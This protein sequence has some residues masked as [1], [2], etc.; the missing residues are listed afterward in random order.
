MIVPRDKYQSFVGVLFADVPAVTTFECRVKRI[1]IIAG[2]AVLVCSCSA[3][4][5]LSGVIEATSDAGGGGMSSTAVLARVDL[6]TLGGRTSVAADINSRDVVVGSS[7]TVT[8]AVHGFRWSAATGMVD[9]GTLAGDDESRAVAILDGNM[10]GGGEILGLS[11]R[12]GDWTP[13]VW[14]ASGSISALPI[15][16]LPDAQLSNP[17]GFNMRGQVIGSDA[18]VFQHAWVWSAADGKYDLTANAPPPGQSTEGIA[19]AITG[20]GSVLV[21]TR[22]YPYTCRPVQCWRAY[23]WSERT[24]YVALGTPDDD[25]AVGVIGYGLNDRGTVVGSVTNAQTGVSPYRW[26]GGSG[27]TLLARLSV[28]YSVGHAFAVN[29]SGT[30]VGIDR[31]PN[32]GVSVAT[33]WPPSGGIVRL[34][35]GDPAPSIA[36]AINATG[37]IAGWALALGGATHA[38]IW[39][40][41]VDMLGSRSAAATPMHDNASTA[42]TRCVADVSSIMSR[43]KLTACVIEADRN[44]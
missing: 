25:P 37:T 2:I 32:S 28:G 7:E 38:V 44:R 11:G 36:I 9:L 23:V 12:S 22:L 17:T 35:P 13:V 8:G 14:S 18:I 39:T 10:L 15:P 19:N 34:S 31:E 6:G 1:G 20:S 3:P 30:V 33:A 5:S 4:E 24:G 21:T 42:T 41:A 29:A 16:L 43:Q 40:P 27:F 26:D